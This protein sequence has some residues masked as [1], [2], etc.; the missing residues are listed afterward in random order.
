MVVFGMARFGLI[1]P[2]LLLSC[3]LLCFLFNLMR[4]HGG[5]LLRRRSGATVAHHGFI[6]IVAA[7]VLAPALRL[8]VQ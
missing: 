7:E 4:Q 8:L 3:L 1:F 6:K 2:V 5:L